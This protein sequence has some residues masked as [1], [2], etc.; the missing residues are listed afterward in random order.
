LRF[1][2]CGNKIRRCYG[3]KNGQ[4]S[5]IHGIITFVII[6]YSQCAKVSFEILTRVDLIGSNGSSAN[7]SSVVFLSGDTEFFGSDHLKFAVPA[8]FVVCYIIL[9]PTLLI[10]HPLYHMVKGFM[11]KRKILKEST[12]GRGFGKC[13]LFIA[14]INLSLK[15]LLDAF[16]GCFKDNM[17]WYAGLF[18]ACRL[19]IS[20]AFAFSTTAASMF[21]MLELIILCMVTI[22]SICQPYQ[23]SFHNILDSLILANLAIINAISLF[24]FAYNIKPSML[25]AVVQLIMIYLPIVYAVVFVI[26]KVSATCS[27]TV[28]AKLKRINDY[29][30]IYDPSTFQFEDVV[31]ENEDSFNPNNLPARLFEEDEQRNVDADQTIS[32]TRERSSIQR[33]NTRYGT[34]GHTY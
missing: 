7:Y 31:A 24:N 27:K 25:L 15:P 28:R 26:L 33:N 21:F 32:L 14:K 8:A 34:I 16:Q 20:A 19:L 18:F 10:V 12:T 4:Y 1:C 23:K 5:A 17:R 13:S 29:I 11:L 6:T 3:K 2:N 22:N 30:L 9:L